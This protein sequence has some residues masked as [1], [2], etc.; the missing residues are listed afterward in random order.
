MAVRTEIRPSDATALTAP[1]NEPSVSPTRVS[2]VTVVLASRPAGTVSRRSATVDMPSAAG[3]PSTPPAS[4]D[5]SRTTGS[6]P[7][8]R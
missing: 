5:R 2:A 8:L 3:L 4:A 6:E 7:R 1:P